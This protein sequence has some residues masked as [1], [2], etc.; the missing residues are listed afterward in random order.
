M[1]QINIRDFVSCHSPMDIGNEGV[2]MV[3]NNVRHECN[4]YNF[5]FVGRKYTCI[6]DRGIGDSTIVDGSAMVLNTEL[7]LPFDLAVINLS[8]AVYLY[9]SAPKPEQ[10]V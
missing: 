9:K 6:I 4:L 8:I 3:Y 10:N 5:F 1:K 2:S 7:T